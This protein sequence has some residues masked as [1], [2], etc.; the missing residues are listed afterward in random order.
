M[1]SEPEPPAP[2]PP[3]EP[4]N[5]RPPTPPVGVGKPIIVVNNP[6][7]PAPPTDLAKKRKLGDGDGPVYAP[8]I[9]T[10]PS[11]VK[12]L[13]WLQNE[14]R[15]DGSWAGGEAHT[16]LALLAFLGRLGAFKAWDKTCTEALIGSQEYD[17]HWEPLEEYPG[18]SDVYAT[19]L[20]ALTLEVYTRVLETGRPKIDKN[21]EKQTVFRS[22]DDD[23]EVWPDGVCSTVPRDR[24]RD[25]FCACQTLSRTLSKTKVQLC[26]MIF[27]KME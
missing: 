2:E 16:G 14:E 3:K 6:A 19:A 23:A 26:L 18:C 24:Y 20:C 7:P 11:V 13:D 22:F 5:T 12:A 4:Q 1:T 25:M 9:A 10:D 15:E 21:Q 17:G 8:G 27:D